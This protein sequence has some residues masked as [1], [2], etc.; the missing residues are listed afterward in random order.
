MAVRAAGVWPN[1]NPQQVNLQQFEVGPNEM[2]GEAE[3]DAGP[4]SLGLDSCKRSRLLVDLSDL[5]NARPGSGGPDWLTLPKCAGGG[6]VSPPAFHSKKRRR[7]GSWGISLSVPSET[8]PVEVNPPFLSGLS[9]R[10]MHACCESTAEK[11][12]WDSDARRSG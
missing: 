10:S 5:E 12:C 3:H 9:A 7:S 2:W 4:R 6:N 8:P 1:S 11:L